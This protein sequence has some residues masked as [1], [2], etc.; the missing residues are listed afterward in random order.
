[1]R[2]I[3]KNEYY[4]LIYIYIQTYVLTPTSVSFKE[5]PARGRYKAYFL[6]GPNDNYSTSSPLFS[7][8]F[9]F[10]FPTVEDSSSSFESHRRNPI[11]DRTEG[12]ASNRL[13]FSQQVQLAIFISISSFSL[14]FVFN[15]LSIFLRF[16]F[17]FFIFFFPLNSK[18]SI[19]LNTY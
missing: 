2:G 12:C 4:F 1:M 9:I 3:R 8:T 18:P 16:S 7:F 15:N 10:A 13:N 6:I 19:I 14:S 11:N 17:L 5:A